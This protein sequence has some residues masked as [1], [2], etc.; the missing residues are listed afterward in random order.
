M[1]KKLIS[2]FNERVKPEDTVFFLG[3]LGFKSGTGRGEGEPQK[4]K[5]ILQQLHCKNIIFIEGN[6]D[7][8]GKNGFKTP[9][10]K[11][12]IR[13]GG[14]KLCLIHNPEHADFNYKINICGHVH[15]KWIFKRF[16]AGAQFTDCINVSVEQWN[17]YPVTWEDIQKKYIRWIK[18]NEVTLEK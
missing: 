5:T 7:R 11:I 9:I 17:Y 13:H 18:D 10:E 8:N 1:N 14:Q 3:D 15:E 2:N 4:P 12:V 16:M 6:H